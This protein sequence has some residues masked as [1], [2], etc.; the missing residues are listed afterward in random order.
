MIGWIGDLFAMIVEM[1]VRLSCVMRPRDPPGEDHPP[2]YTERPHTLYLGATRSG[3]TTSAIAVDLV[4]TA[5]ADDCFIFF[6]DPHVTGGVNFAG[7]V[8]EAGMEDRLIVYDLARSAYLGFGVFY[9]SR[10][11]CPHKRRKENFRHAR[12]AAEALAGH[13]PG[14]IDDTRIIK[15]WLLAAI[16]LL[17]YQQTDVPWSMLIQA[18]YPGTDGF[19]FLLDGCTD[20]A[21][22]AKFQSL[23][24]M[25]HNLYAAIGPTLRLLEETLN[26]PDFAELVGGPDTI[27]IE[28]CMRQRKIVVFLG[29][30][31]ES[32]DRLVMRLFMLRV[33]QIILS[34]WARTKKPLPARLYL[35][36]AGVVGRAESW[37]ASATLKMGCS[38]VL[39]TQ[40][41]A[42]GDEL[43]DRRIKANATRVVIMHAGSEEEAREGASHLKLSLDEQKVHHETE[44]TVHDGYEGVR[45][46]KTSHGV[47]HGE[48]GEDRETET[49]TE[50]TRERAVHRR[51]V[52]KHYQTL[53]DQGVLNERAIMRLLAGQAFV[54]DGSTLEGP[55][56][57]PMLPLP[58]Q[59]EGGAQEAVDELIGRHLTDGILRGPGT[60]WTPPPPA[61]PPT[62]RPPKAKANPP[63]KGRGAAGRS[64][65]NGSGRP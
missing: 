25:R 33:F 65:R 5:E 36:E 15:E 31:D 41:L 46:V 27:D 34:S 13:R 61:P 43:V 44:R 52:D 7:H 3:K 9:R 39:L 23:L 51:V 2:P 26:W 57:L 59:Y 29:S 63:K 11:P 24:A 49:T 50:G 48:D 19:H 47:S 55:V 42:T 60:P 21:V 54:R 12:M 56:Q 58:F 22:R 16:T 20:P 8:I 45:D 10:D 37:A 62:K 6:G 53:A 18:F 17:Q 28:R 1:L 30:G 35:D 40:V 32:Y 4:P 14:S 38:M 64:A